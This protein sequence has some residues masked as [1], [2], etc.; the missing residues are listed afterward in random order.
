MKMWKSI[1][2][3][4]PGWIVFMQAFITFLIPF[5]ISGLFKWIRSTKEDQ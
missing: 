5:T 4:L 2:S 1:V 3:Y